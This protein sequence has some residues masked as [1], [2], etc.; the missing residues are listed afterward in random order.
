MMESLADKI[1]NNVSS[2]ESTF[3]RDDPSTWISR[4]LEVSPSVYKHQGFLVHEH[5]IIEKG[6]RQQIMA[7]LRDPDV[8]VSSAR[9]VWVYDEL[10]SVA[11]ELSYRFIR[12]SNEY[13]WDSKRCE[14]VPL[15][16]FSD[17]VTQSDEATKNIREGNKYD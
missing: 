2:N 5:E 6:N 11:P 14:L 15:S 4:I 10:M 8:A 9:A 13:V 1:I 16:Q 17:C 12:V 7:L 3:D